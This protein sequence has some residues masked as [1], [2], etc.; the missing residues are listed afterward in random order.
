MEPL[1][2]PCQR[3]I[4]R[5]S[6]RGRWTRYKPGLIISFPFTGMIMLQVNLHN[7][8]QSIFTITHH[9]CPGY[10]LITR[11]VSDFRDAGHVDLGSVVLKEKGESVP[12]KEIVCTKEQKANLIY[13]QR[14]GKRY[15]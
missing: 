3:P 11:N 4:Q 13:A 2:L 14:Q 12:S 15:Q 10:M 6:L 5:V 9:L 7:S 1:T 8:V